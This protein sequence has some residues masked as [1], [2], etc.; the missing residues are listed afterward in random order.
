MDHVVTPEERLFDKL[1]R[2]RF[3]SDGLARGLAGRF[4]VVAAVLRAPG[5]FATSAARRICGTTRAAWS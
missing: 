1:D 2:D 5:A 3:D 4:S